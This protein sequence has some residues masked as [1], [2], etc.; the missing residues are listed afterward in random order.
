MTGAKKHFPSGVDRT[1]PSRHRR[2][3]H[4]PQSNIVT[5]TLPPFVLAHYSLFS[6][7]ITLPQPPPPTH[8]THLNPIKPSTSTYTTHLTLLNPLP[9][10]HPP[11]PTTNLP[12]IPRARH[13]TLRRRA[14]HRRIWIH[15]RSTPALPLILQPKPLVPAIQTSIRTRLHRHR[16]R[17]RHR[18]IKRPPHG[19]FDVA[20][21]RFVGGGVGQEGADVVGAF[22]V[23]AVLIGGLG[24]GERREGGEEGEEKHGCGGFPKASDWG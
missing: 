20:L 24:E 1:S 12:R 17:P 14:R 4:Q 16:I 9:I 19:R 18:R 15:P 7:L 21:Y 5:A 22:S 23:A 13:P 6:F 11:T 8:I 3:R 10:A 2:E